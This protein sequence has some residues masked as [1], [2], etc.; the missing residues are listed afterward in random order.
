[1]SIEAR[2]LLALVD[3]GD[4]LAEVKRRGLVPAGEAPGGAL[5]VG[6]LRVDPLACSARW[7]GLTVAL[8]RRETEV[9]YALA[10]ARWRGARWVRAD[11]LTARVWRVDDPPARKCLYVVVS[12]L[13]A[14]LPGLIVGVGGGTGSAGRYGLD[15]DADEVAA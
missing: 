2:A 1:M 6:R 7:L 5:S 8:T 11:R 15:L 12:R 9:L 10:V 14:K 13:R 4:L 3:D